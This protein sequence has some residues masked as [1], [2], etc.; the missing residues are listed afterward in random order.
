VSKC[1]DEEHLLP[2]VPKAYEI[3]MLYPLPII[4]YLS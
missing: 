4:Y 1:V 3:Y 2:Y